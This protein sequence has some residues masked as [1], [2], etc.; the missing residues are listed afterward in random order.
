MTSVAILSRFNNPSV[1]FLEFIG[2]ILITLVDLLIS[3]MIVPQKLEIFLIFQPFSDMKGQR[4]NIEDMLTG[5]L[6]VISHGIEKS[7]L[8]AEYIVIDQMIMHFA[9]FYLC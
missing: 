2:F 8:V 1:L 4:N 9:F 6:I 7:F 5:L 3:F